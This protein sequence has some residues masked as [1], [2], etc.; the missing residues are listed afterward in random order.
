MNTPTAKHPVNQRKESISVVVAVYN[1][2][3]YICECVDSIINQ[4]I[5]PE[6]IILV[7][8]GSTDRSSALCDEYAEKNTNIRVIHQKNAGLSA[9]RNTGIEHAQG[10]W[11]YFVDGDD[12]LAPDVIESFLAVLTAHEGDVEFIQGRMTWFVDGSN[13]FKPD[14]VYIP[15]EWTYFA[16]SQL[17]MARMLE[18]KGA[19]RMG[20][21]GLYRR[22]FLIQNDLMFVPGLYSEDQ[23]WTPRLFSL[24]VKMGSNENPGYLYRE[25]RAGSI[26]TARKPEQVE[27]LF[28]LYQEWFDRFGNDS[29][30]DVRFR[31]ALKNEAAR[32]SVEEL[33]KH[34][35]R[36]DGEDLV[37]VEEIVDRYRDLF[38]PRESMAFREKV[39]S[40]FVRVFGARSAA[41]ITRWLIQWRNKGK[42]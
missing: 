1:I 26:V 2:E 28:T 10:V 8:D 23:E 34:I 16:K 19:F 15:D 3:D 27:V 7:D 36:L 38:V 9:A 32:R 5:Q 42:H 41:K 29:S 12:I 6:E 4:T 21:R 31:N 11:V 13:N 24:D 35:E 17:V 25:G 37:T 39:L 22:N 40:F 33:Y 30:L 14:E 18:E 20:I